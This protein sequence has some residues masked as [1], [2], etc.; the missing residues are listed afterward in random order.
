M[1]LAVVFYYFHLFK[2]HLKCLAAARIR[3]HATTKL[4]Q[5]AKK[6]RILKYSVK[7]LFDPT[8]MEY[9]VY[10]VPFSIPQQARKP[11]S[12]SFI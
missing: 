10:V 11:S 1:L 3:R 12:F 4:F 7:N 6:L 8:S 5:I 2:R 9:A